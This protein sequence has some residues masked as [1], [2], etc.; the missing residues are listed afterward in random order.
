MDFFDLCRERHSVRQYDPR[1][2]E[3][4]KLERI[5]EAGRLAPTAC[6]Y[7]PQRIYVIQSEEARNKLSGL[8][9]MTYQ[10]P[11]SLLVCYDKNE[12]WKCTQ[13]TFGEDYEG[14]EMDAC[15]VGTQMMNMATELGLGTLWARGFNAQQIHDAFGLPENI[16][17]V[18]LLDIGYPAPGSV[19]RPTPR[20][21]LSAT[22]T[23][24]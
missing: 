21:E 14:G 24:L 3:N 20:K 13:K 17:V 19:S 9:R 8:T 18:F 4:E 12:S 1:P 7:Q 11:V 2:V 16:V 10:A 22:V 6:N 23:Q 15:I 5:L